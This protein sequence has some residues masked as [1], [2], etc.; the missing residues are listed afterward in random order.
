MLNC[1]SFRGN[2]EVGQE[3][4]GAEC[5][6]LRHSIHRPPDEAFKGPPSILGGVNKSIFSAPY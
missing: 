2:L 5:L 3:R 4:G 6:G 1:V